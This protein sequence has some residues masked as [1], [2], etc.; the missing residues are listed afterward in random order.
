MKRYRLW[1]PD[2]K[3]PKFLISR[4]MTFNESIILNPKK[5]NVDKDK[6]HE[7]SKQVELESETSGKRQDSISIQPIKEN[8]QD[9]RRMH[10]RNN[11]IVLLLGDRG[12]K[13]NHLK[14]IIAM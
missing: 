10:K 6:D 1:C 3:L 4:D 9:V 11:S 2:P 7:V 13:L 14:G 12:E 5:K 8:E